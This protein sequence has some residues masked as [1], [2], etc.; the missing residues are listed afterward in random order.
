MAKPKYRLTEK[1]Y[2]KVDVPGVGLE[3]TM[4]DP[5]A[6]PLVDAAN[7][8]GPRTPLFV[9]YEGRPGPHMLPANDEAEEMYKKFPPKLLD[10]IRDMTM[11]VAADEEVAAVVNEAKMRKEIE[12]RVRMEIEI[13][14][15][16]EAEMAGKK[17]KGK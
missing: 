10:P 11:V 3:D 7:P 17:V 15:K 12:A 1:D 6:Q 2:M 16:V 13:R 14:L 9:E 4:L 8:L 5:E